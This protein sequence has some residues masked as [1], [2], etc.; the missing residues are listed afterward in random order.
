ML[1]DV[2]VTGVDRY[3]QSV[4]F[5]HNTS[6]FKVILPPSIVK[7]HH[8]HTLQPLKDAALK[9]LVVPASSTAAERSFSIA[10]FFHQ[11]MFHTS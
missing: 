8:S 11:S 10:G 7:G 3:K 4:H 6:T 5:W 1:A 2:D 9:E